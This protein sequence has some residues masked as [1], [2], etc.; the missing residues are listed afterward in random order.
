MDTCRGCSG[1]GILAVPLTFTYNVLPVGLL[2]NLNYLTNNIGSVD[3]K[4]CVPMWATL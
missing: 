4:A 3:P 1:C 2:N